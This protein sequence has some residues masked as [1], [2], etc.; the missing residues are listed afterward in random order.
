MTGKVKKLTVCI[1]I[2]RFFDIFDSKKGSIWIN[3]KTVWQDWTENGVYDIYLY[4]HIL[5]S[6]ILKKTIKDNTAI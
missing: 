2:W 6:V 5:C 1:D 3:C 4:A